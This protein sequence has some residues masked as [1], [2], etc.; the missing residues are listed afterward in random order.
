MKKHIRRIL[1]W[2]LFLLFLV[3][4]PIAMLYSQGYRFDQKRMIF[5]HSGSI[6][7]KS[8]PTSVNVFVD[9]K[10]Q[11]TNNLDIINNSVTVGGL[12]PGNYQH[13]GNFGRIWQLGKK[14]RGS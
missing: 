5:V 2:L 13:R 6:T 9:G 1:F 12:R 10:P 4:T 11:S 8:L 7:L 14:R 3:T